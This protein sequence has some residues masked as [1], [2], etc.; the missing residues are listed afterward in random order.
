MN[1][2]PSYS[3]DRKK[4]LIQILIAVG[5]SIF[6]Q[7]IIDPFIYD[8]YIREFIGGMEGGDA[9]VICSLSMTSMCGNSKTPV[10]SEV[11]F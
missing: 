6:F 1:E 8:P 2:K 3:L 7:F 11:T 10:Y 4:F 9:I 5:I